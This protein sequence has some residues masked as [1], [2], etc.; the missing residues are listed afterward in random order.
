MSSRV[1]TGWGLPVGPGSGAGWTS[2]VSVSVPVASGASNAARAA[3]DAEPAQIQLLVGR[4]TVLNVGAP[5][6]RV[7]LTRPEIAEYQAR[8]A[9]EKL[10]KSGLAYDGC[11]FDNFMMSQSWQNHDIY[12]KP[13]QIDADGDGKPDKPEDLDRAWRAGVFHELKTWRKLMPWALT[14]GHSQGYPHPDIAE[15]FNGQGIGFMTTD[16]IEGKAKDPAPIGDTADKKTSPADTKAPTVD[17]ALAAAM[18]AYL[19][20]AQAAAAPTGNGHKSEVTPPLA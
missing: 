16:V 9:Y 19:T 2:Y 14:T 8:Y 7:S 1:W 3:A 4:S 17:P 18:L 12:D 11:F 15:I 6:V 10:L 5:I 20:Q 13:V